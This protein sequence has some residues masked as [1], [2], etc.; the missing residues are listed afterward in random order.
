MVSE[1]EKRILTR[2]Q[3]TW[4]VTTSSL[5]STQFIFLV[6]WRS[7]RFFYFTDFWLR[8]NYPRCPFRKIFWSCECIYHSVWSNGNSYSS[9]TSSFMPLI[10]LI[11]Y[12]YLFV[13]ISIIIR[14]LVFFWVTKLKLT[15]K[16]TKAILPC[17]CAASLEIWILLA[18]S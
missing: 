3:T 18:S 10:C 6:T 9:S 17:I 1:I 11:V 15:S 13:F 16:I 7:W 14:W 2:I 5:K 4:V 12:F 8:I